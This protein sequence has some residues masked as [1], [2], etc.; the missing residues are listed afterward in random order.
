MQQSLILE[1]LD[2]ALREVI[3][4]LGGYKSVGCALRPELTPEKAGQWLRDCVNSE[5]RERLEPSQV[6]RILKL[7]RAANLHTLMDWIAREIGYRV[8]PLSKDD[9]ALMLK[10]QLIEAAAVLKTATARLE[11]MGVRL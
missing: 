10:R 7:A 5:R 2:D 9:E 11:A 8:E 6:L 3:A 4:Q 1:D